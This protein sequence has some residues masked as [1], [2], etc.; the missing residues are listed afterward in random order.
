MLQI[1]HATT[2]KHFAHAHQLIEEMARWDGEQSQRLGLDPQEVMAFFYSSD[3]EE[4]RRESEPPAGCL[5]LATVADVPAGC[6][7]FRRID[8]NACELHNVYVRDQ[9]RGKRIARQMVEQLVATAK[10][11]GYSVMRLETTPFMPEAQA[12][13][14][15]IGFRLRG[16]YRAVP[17]LFAPWTVFM[18]LALAAPR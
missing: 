14:A 15:S 13:Y 11:A 12:L 10:D 1:S 9:F 5:L 2:D 17:E 16:P 4:L 3:D 8:E 6:A 7:A 18:E